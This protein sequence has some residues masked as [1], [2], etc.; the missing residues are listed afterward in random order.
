MLFTNFK[1][2]N[3]KEILFVIG[4]LVPPCGKRPGQK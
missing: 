3:E 2:K 1:K 4:A